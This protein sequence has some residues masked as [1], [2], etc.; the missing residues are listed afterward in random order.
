MWN[1]IPDLKAYSLKKNSKKFFFSKILLL[2][3]LKKKRKNYCEKKLL[4][5][6]IKNPYWNLTLGQCWSAFKQLD[7]VIAI[8]VKPL[9][10]RPPIKAFY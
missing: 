5:K 8:T 4:N 3:A 10:S 1:I 6:R 9:L 2:D 7:P